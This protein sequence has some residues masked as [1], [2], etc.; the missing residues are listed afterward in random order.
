MNAIVTALLI[1]LCANADES[2][3]PIMAK[4]IVYKDDHSTRH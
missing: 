4:R 2:S 1:S 3:V